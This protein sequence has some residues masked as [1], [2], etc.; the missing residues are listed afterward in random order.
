MN[1]NVQHRD[2]RHEHDEND[3]AFASGTWGAAWHGRHA[4]SRAGDGAGQEDVRAGPDQPAGAVLQP[5]ERRRAEGGRCGRGRAGDLQRQQR[6]RPRRTTRSRPTSSRAWTASSS[7]PS[8]SNGIMP[9]VD[10]AAD[11]AGIP[12]VAVDAILPEDGPQTAQIGVDNEGA[13]AD[14]RAFRRSMCRHGRRRQA[15]HRRRAEL[16][17]PEHPPEGLRGRV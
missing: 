14:R 6:S 8:T 15:R 4:V 16:D 7:S 9:A 2:M 12:V 13:G 1:R 10:Q 5:D 11:A 17:H 3:C